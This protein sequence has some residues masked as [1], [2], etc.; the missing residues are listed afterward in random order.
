MDE[1]YAFVY[2][3]PEDS[4]KFLV[5]CLTMNDKLL[6]DAFKDGDSQPVHAEIK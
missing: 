5:R 1:D 4:K 6:I 3:N 2:H